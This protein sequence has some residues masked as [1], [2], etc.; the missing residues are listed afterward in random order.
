MRLVVP[1]PCADNCRMLWWFER[2]GRHT[3]VEVLHLPAGGFE[4]RIVN[5]N[6]SEQVEQFM[7]AG[8]LAKRQQTVQD[9]LIAQGWKR[10]GE[11]LLSLSAPTAND[12]ASPSRLA[13]EVI[14]VTFGWRGNAPATTAEA[15]PSTSFPKPPFRAATRVRA[16][17]TMRGWAC[18]L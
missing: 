5:E 4:L 12:A 2:E 11:W 17:L 8:D 3:R 15:A 14:A 1:S 16:R 10:S 18:A 9:A 13:A 7:D 6:G